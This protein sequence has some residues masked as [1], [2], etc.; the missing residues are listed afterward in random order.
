MKFALEEKFSNLANGSI[1]KVS[2]ETEYEV[3]ESERN[4]EIL[5]RFV[6]TREI[7]NQNRVTEIRDY[8]PIEI[9]VPKNKIIKK[10]AEVSLLLK[11]FRI[12]LEGDFAIFGVEV[13][14]TNVTTSLPSLINRDKLKDNLAEKAINSGGKRYFDNELID[15]YRLLNY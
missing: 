13:E 10:T 12:E 1:K 7:K 2:T 6:V 9:T 3:R 4:I 11:E 14:L 5:G 15:A 8:L